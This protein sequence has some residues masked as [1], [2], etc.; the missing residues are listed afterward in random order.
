[1][2]LGVSP[3]YREVRNL[4][5]VA[6]RFF[7][8]QDAASQTKV[9]VIVEPFAKALYGS[10]TRP[11]TRNITVKGFRSSSSASSRGFQYLRPIG[12]QRPDPADSLS[13]SALLHRHRHGKGALL[14]HERLVH[15]GAAKRSHSR[16]H[17]IAATIRLNLQRTAAHRD[18]SKRKDREHADNCTTLAAGITL[19]VSG[20]GIMNSM[21][22]NVQARIREIGIRKALG[23]TSL[24]IRMQFL[25]EAVFLSLGRRSRRY[26]AWPCH[27][28][29]VR[30]FNAVQDSNQPWSAV[31]ALTTSIWSAFSSEHF[32]PIVQPASIPCKPS[33]TSNCR[34][35]SPPAPSKQNASTSANCREVDAFCVVKMLMR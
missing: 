19:I 25:T 13:R 12:D 32:R 5:V 29:D 7:D 1:M 27:S 18:L 15:G 10:S 14:H 35:P 31:A 9:A 28:V 4:A 3:Q 22:A 11:S 33:S 30:P 21:L 16:D 8:D 2:L 17:P 24:E 20:V 6:G 23:A 26:I 34:T